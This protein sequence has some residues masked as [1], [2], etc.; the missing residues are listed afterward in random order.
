MCTAADVDL[1][2]IAGLGFPQSKGG[3]LHYADELGLQTVLTE[4]E[5]LT[6]AYGERFWPSPLLKRMVAA[7][8]VGKQAG[9]GFFTYPG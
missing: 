5:R 3:M 2:V 9:K 8:H 4:L 1:S 6:K 7:G